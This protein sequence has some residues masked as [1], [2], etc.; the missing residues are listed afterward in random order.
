RIFDIVSEIEKQVNSLRRQAAKTRRYKI[1]QEEYRVLMRHFFAAEGNFLSEM[2]G[3]LSLQLERAIER[4]HELAAQVEAK[5]KSV[6]EATQSARERED[7]LSEIR[8]RHSA[9]ALERDRAEREHR[10]QAEQIVAL[11]HRIET[12]LGEIEATKQ[13]QSMVA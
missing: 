13:R 6:R 4:E 10:Y 11:N 8:Q 3:S 5:E 7:A 12:I 9:N 2:I 1:L